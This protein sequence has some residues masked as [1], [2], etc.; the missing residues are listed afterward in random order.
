LI[1]PGAERP[2]RYH[3]ASPE[4]Q[5]TA[6]Q[7]D[8]DR[9]LYSSAFRRLAGITQIA[10]AGESDVFHTRLAHTLKV[11]QVGRRLAEFVIASQTAEAVTLGIDPEV[12]EAACLA[13]DL[14]HPPFGHLGEKALNQLVTEHGDQDGF[15]GNAQSFRALTKLAVRF[16][17]CDGLDLTRATLAACI[18]YPWK[19]D[20]THAAKSRK[21]GYYGV[22]ADEFQF[23]RLGS[24]EETKTAEAELMDWADD[25]A[26]SV[27]DLED[28]HRCGVVPWRIVFS[29]AGRDELVKAILDARGSQSRQEKRDLQSAHR[30][31]TEL[32]E[33]TVGDRLDEPYEATKEQR[34]TIRLM[35]STFIGRY[36]TATR[37]R[38]PKAA[39]TYLNIPNPIQS[40]VAILKEITRRYIITIPA[41]VGQQRGQERLLNELF[42][43]LYP[44]GSEKYLPRRF[45]YLLKGDHSRARRVADC[46][47]GLTEA[48]TI[49][50]HRRL[51]GH[52]SGSVLDPIVR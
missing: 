31:L 19:R 47:S 44:V 46:I 40:E 17:A 33:G 3:S 28:F 25:I 41:L 16:K 7:R 12:V 15:E 29:E 32:V 5:R 27:H 9:I 39:Q 8:R 23:A 24:T 26:Y 30:R 37:V 38:V 22:D 51:R 20:P 6:Y 1:I 45:E 13:H 43:D 2:I 52:E 50:L 21:W 42:E 4:D 10:R 35:T 11:A 18:K 34:Q 14:G 49:A 48:E 36:V